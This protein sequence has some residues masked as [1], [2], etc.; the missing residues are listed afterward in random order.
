MRILNLDFFQFSVGEILGLEPL[1]K[2]DF[3]RHIDIQTRGGYIGWNWKNFNYENNSTNQKTNLL[4][5]D[6]NFN[7]KN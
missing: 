3:S 4:D 5:L 2:T 7:K 1:S 6:F